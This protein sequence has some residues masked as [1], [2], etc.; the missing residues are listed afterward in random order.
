MHSAPPSSSPTPLASASSP[1]PVPVAVPAAP[2]PAPA[3]EAEAEEKAAAPEENGE[4]ELEPMR[5][6]AGHTSE[7]ES[8]DS[9]VTPGDKENS[10]GP[11]QDIEGRGMAPCEHFMSTMI[12]TNKF[13]I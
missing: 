3:P 10:T 5:N 7:T 9:G 8:S 2:S 4:M 1:A 13:A 12:V 11:S 6:G